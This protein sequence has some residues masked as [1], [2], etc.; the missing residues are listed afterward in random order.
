MVR[1]LDRGP[2]PPT[3][4][5]SFRGAGCAPGCRPAMFRSSVFGWTERCPAGSRWPRPD[6]V[7]DTLTLELSW[8]LKRAERLWRGRQAECRRLRA[9]AD[10]SWLRAP[11]RCDYQLP[12]A[13]QLEL[14][15]LSSRIKPS[16]CGPVILSFRKLVREFDPEVQEVPRLFRST[17]LEFIERDEEETSQ[18]WVPQQ[19]GRKWE[20]GRSLI[21]LRSRL[22]IHPFCQE[23]PGPG[24]VTARRA[25]S[26][27]EFDLREED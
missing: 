6:L 26:M 5:V 4:A 24:Q 16:Q 1:G 13:E 9:G 10:Y 22:R 2:S 11:P 12:P 25:R 14:R 19:L 3:H 23:A 18:R 21:T 8:Q 27:P 20:Q 7:A 17:V 15:E